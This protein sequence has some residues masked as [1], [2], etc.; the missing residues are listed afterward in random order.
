MYHPNSIEGNQPTLAD[1]SR[2][3]R[4]TGV[5]SAGQKLRSRS[6]TFADHFSQAR[7]FLRSQS[8]PER[9]HLIDACCFEL[10]HVERLAIRERVVFLFAQIDEDFAALVA[11]AIGVTFPVAGKPVGAAARG[12]DTARDQ[13][14]PALSLV[15]AARRSLQTRKVAL[16]VGPGVSAEDLGAAM[17]QLGGKGAVVHVIAPTLGIVQ[18][19]EDGRD[20]AV[21]KSLMTTSSVLYDAVYVPGGAESIETLLQVPAALEFVHLAFRHGKAI[22]ATNEGML[23]LAAARLPGPSK[24]APTSQ[25]T[26]QQ[27]VVTARGKQLEAFFTAF[28]EAIADHRHFDRDLPTIAPPKSSRRPSRRPSRGTKP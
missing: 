27:G 21:Q 25:P 19:D 22:G 6:A 23:L 17:Q 7:M 4:S 9:Q 15:S 18:A 16:L 26:V 28:A 2:G 14:S 10:G 11:G 13:T 12:T 24:H 8:A 1:P 5:G 3:F 20:V